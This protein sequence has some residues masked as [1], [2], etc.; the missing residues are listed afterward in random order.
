MPLLINN[1]RVICYLKYKILEVMKSFKISLITAL[2]F[3]L[4]GGM[5]LTSCN[6]KEDD[7]KPEILT[8]K[9][10][11]IG[12]WDF[13]D[14]DV[15]MKVDNKSYSQYLADE[16]KLSR[17][18]A[19]EIVDQMEEVYLVKGGIDFRNDGTFS[20]TFDASITEEGKWLVDANNV[21]T[22]KLDNDDME[23]TI[24]ELSDKTLI[25]SKTHTQK[26]DLNNDDKLESLKVEITNTLTKADNTKRKVYEYNNTRFY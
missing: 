8:L 24:K 10:S 12:H 23:L 13:E 18:A 22:L 26:Q 25:V 19:N 5:L 3:F 11:L 20:Q 6:K 1:N 4:S 7:P 2:F 9:T 15:N 14:C 21:L 17:S 16:L